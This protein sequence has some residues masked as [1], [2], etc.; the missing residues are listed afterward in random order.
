MSLKSHAAL[1][2]LAGALFIGLV[3]VTALAQWALGD[4]L[5]VIQQPLQNVPA[6]VLPGGELEISCV[7]DPGQTG[8]AASLVRDTFDI[9]LALTA[10][11]YDSQTEWWRLTASVPQVPIFELYGLRVTA[12]GGV[13]D[14]ARNAVKVQAEFPEDF[15]LVHITDTH[16]PT[17]L[18]NYQSGAATDSS[19]TISLRHITQDVNIINPAFVLLTGDLIHEGEL[20]DYLNRRYFSRAQQQLREFAMPVFVTAG[21]HDIGG[22]D[23]TPPSDGT[24]RRNWWRF[25]GWPRLDD[26]PAAVPYRTQ[27]YSFDYGEVHFAGLEAYDNYDNWRSQYYGH[28]SF[29]SMQMQWLQQDLAAT[30]RDVKVLFHHFDFADELNLSALGLDMSL[31]GHTHRD[32]EDYSHPYDVVTDNAGGTNRPFRLVRYINGQLSTQPS[33]EAGYNGDALTVNYSPANDGAHDQVT[34]TIDN[35]YFERFEY[36]LLKINMPAGSPGFTVNGGTLLQVDNTGDHAVCYIN[37]LIQSN[38]TTT[39]VVAVDNAAPVSETPG[40]TR[41]VQAHPNPFNPRTEISFQLEK[42]GPCRLAIFDLHGREVAVLH[43]GLLN[44]DNH[45]FTWTGTDS[46]GQAMPSGVYFAALRAGG[47]NET[48]KLTLVR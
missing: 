24:A 42:A 15:Y 31:S 40:V 19:N 7:A 22:W 10:A 9:P 39:V 2:V 4:T 12:D 14:L 46:Q 43:Q 32:T 41:L 16:L 26:P 5:T 48:R 27:N 47:Y 1:A 45:S 36:G 11:V 17:Y 13:D 6:I 20:E 37:V 38:R 44:A 35:G 25:F 21:N 30:D 33:L 23:D 29:T 18:Y 8:W 28:E 34:A 3:P